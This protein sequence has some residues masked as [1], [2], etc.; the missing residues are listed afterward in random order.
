M[1]DFDVFLEDQLQ[2]FFNK[3]RGTKDEIVNNFNNLVREH[4]SQLNDYSISFTPP[5]SEKPASRETVSLSTLTPVLINELKLETT[6]RGRY[7]QVTVTSK[8]LIYSSVSCIV[9]DSTGYL[10]FT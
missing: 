9:E 10:N 3:T 7:I 8:I 6:H 5:T 1:S 2:K 4:L